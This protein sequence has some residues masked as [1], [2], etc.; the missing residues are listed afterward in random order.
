MSTETRVQTY[1]SSLRRKEKTVVFDSVCPFNHACLFQHF[2]EAWVYGNANAVMRVTQ[3]CHEWYWY[4]WCYLESRCSLYYITF[5]IWTKGHK[6]INTNKSRLCLTICSCSFWGVSIYSKSC[7][8]N[9]LLDGT[10]MEVSEVWCWLTDPYRARHRLWFG[11]KVWSLGLGKPAAKHVP[12]KTKNLMTSGVQMCSEAKL[13]AKF[14]CVGSFRSGQNKEIYIDRS[15]QGCNKEPL[16]VC[17][18]PKFTPNAFRITSGI[19]SSKLQICTRFVASRKRYLG[20]TSHSL[21]H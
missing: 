8:I 2:C 11:S 21:L 6:W 10:S 12:K 4:E 3:W 16:D 15:A 17:L 7:F 1:F 18:Y 13:E 14:I 9:S 20:S 19:I 5:E